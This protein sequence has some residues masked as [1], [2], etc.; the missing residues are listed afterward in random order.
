M[1]P[2]QF[3]TKLSRVSASLNLRCD[4]LECSLAFP[5]MIN[6]RS[7]F[8]LTALKPELKTSSPYSVIMY[9]LKSSHFKVA[10]SIFF[11]TAL[12]ILV[13]FFSACAWVHSSCS[14]SEQL[15]DPCSFFSSTISE[16]CTVFL[17]LGFLGGL[18][19]LAII[20]FAMSSKSMLSLLNSFSNNSL[21]S[22]F[23]ARS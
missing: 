22:I 23:C 1:Y 18:I 14:F 4:S 6:K 16:S 5:S 21:G 20:S 7:L 15:D 9:A 3:S 8:F 10:I 13:I 19:Y 11:E 2:K 12:S 17:L